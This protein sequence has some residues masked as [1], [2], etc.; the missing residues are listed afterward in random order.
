MGAITM[1]EMGNVLK[2]EVVQMQGHGN[3]LDFAK[4]NLITHLAKP[5]AR[6]KIFWQM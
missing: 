1:G 4:K 2:A 6:V 5:V 3:W